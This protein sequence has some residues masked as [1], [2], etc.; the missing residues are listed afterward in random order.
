MELPSL[1]RHVDCVLHIFKLNDSD[2]AANSGKQI[3]Q[4]EE[5]APRHNATNN[6]VVLKPLRADL[7]YERIH[8][9]NIARD[10]RH[11]PS[12]PPQAGALTPQLGPHAGGLVQDRVRALHGVLDR[13]PLPHQLLHG[14]VVGRPGRARAVLEQLPRL[15]PALDRRAGLLEV[16]PAVEQYLAVALDEERVLRPTGALGDRGHPRVQQV[17]HGGYG[18][19]Y[20]R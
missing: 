19:L 11:G 7:L 13:V 3:P 1:G 4:R 9:G 5:N 6:A 10:L 18:A 2:S 16:A 8:P 17:R 15:A 12:H 14:R 20:V